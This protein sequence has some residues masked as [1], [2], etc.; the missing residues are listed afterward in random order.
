MVDSYHLANLNDT[1]ASYLNTFAPMQLP[2]NIN[3]LLTPLGASMN[4]ILRHLRELGN[5]TLTN[6]TTSYMLLTP[7]DFADSS[8]DLITTNEKFMSSLFA[9]DDASLYRVV[10]RQTSLDALNLASTQVLSNPAMLPLSK[11]NAF[12]TKCLHNQAAGAGGPSPKGAQFYDQMNPTSNVT[13]VPLVVYDVWGEPIASNVVKDALEKYCANYQSMGLHNSLV[14]LDY[15]TL[16]ETRREVYVFKY[17][18]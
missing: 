3:G 9:G 18:I 8:F 10:E 16:S 5:S 12:K 17:V 6:L 11:R 15:N 14:T 2:F 13:V 1:S 7:L 4:K